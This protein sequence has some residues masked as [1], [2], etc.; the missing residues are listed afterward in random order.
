MYNV[1]AELRK[2][3]DHPHLVPDFRPQDTPGLAERLAAAGKLQLLDQLLPRLQAAGQRV[4]L[5]SHSN[6]VRLLASACQRR[7]APGAAPSP[8]MHGVHQ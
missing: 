1:V 6:L 4:L 8:N 2:L 3:C 5:L 7:G